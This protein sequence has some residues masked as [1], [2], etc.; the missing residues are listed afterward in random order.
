MLFCLHYVNLCKLFLLPSLLTLVG[1]RE[2]RDEKWLVVL[3]HRNTV[4]WEK[5]LDLA[6]RKSLTLKDQFKHLYEELSPIHTQNK[7]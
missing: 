3:I 4:Y 2:R 5:L 6:R 7:C 1:D